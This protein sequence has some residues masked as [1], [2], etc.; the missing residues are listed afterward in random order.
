MGIRGKTLLIIGTT[1]LLLVAGIL[2]AAR[3]IVLGGFVQHEQE[4]TAAQLKRALSMLSDRIA[5]L[6]A[7][8][9]DWAEWDDTYE[10]LG[11]TAG[12]DPSS[13]NLVSSAFQAFGLN[14]VV[15]ALPDG[16]PVYAAGWDTDANVPADTPT[17]VLAGLKPGGQ[18]G[19]VAADNAPV[20]G[21][22]VAHD[23]PLIVA[24]RPVLRSDGTGSPRGVLL[25]GY[26]LDD[27]RIDSLAETGRLDGRI[28]F[29]PL[30]TLRN[31]IGASS[32]GLPD[33]GE[34]V[35]DPSDQNLIGATAVLADVTGRPAVL[36]RSQHERPVFQQGRRTVLFFLLSSLGAAL[37][38]AVIVM[39][40]LDRFVL[41]RVTRM[42]RAVQRITASGDVSAGRL[43][44]TGDDELAALSRAVNTMLTALGEAE[45]RRRQSA[46]ALRERE[47]SFRLIAETAQDMIYRLRLTEPRRFEYVS[48]AARTIFGYAPEEFYADV[49]LGLRAMAPDDHDRGGV[50]IDE[51]SDEPRTFTVKVTRR[52]GQPGWVEHQRVVLR[53]EAGKAIAVQGIARDVTSR[54][55]LLEQVAAA[56]EQLRALSRRQVVMQETLQRQ[57][58]REL[59][60][61][62]G[63]TLTGLKLLVEA[64][65]TEPSAVQGRLD[66]AR[67]L[68]LQ[69]MSYVRN[70]SL[71]LRPTML[72]DL[73]LLPALQFL[74]DRFE[75]QTG[76]AVDFRHRGIDKRFAP[77]VET[78]AYRI[79]QEALT[80]VARHA[81]ATGAQVALQQQQGIMAI[82]VR[83]DGDGFDVERA[84]ASPTNSGLTGMRERASALGGTF[85]VQSEPGRGTRLTVVLPAEEDTATTLTAGE[86]VDIGA[87]RGRSRGGPPGSEGAS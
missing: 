62:I 8:A 22:M 72:D 5:G 3:A 19:S 24:A 11:D 16:E 26:W 78:A 25:F 60:D 45:S 31:D 2:V 47:E 7:I 66:K 52:D 33:V 20:A 81:H 1:S 41:S 79:V 29:S 76:L 42:T 53:D 9:S 4:E 73:G 23:R 38:T 40:L 12:G 59:H 44:A 67:E 49:A 57:I 36:A 71:D 82:E 69:L 13:R 14:V 80:N 32:R 34:V 51:P 37:V 21:I 30:S 35:V 6:E 68:V 27:A 65:L 75:S 74:F 58:A 54:M 56:E 84:E 63:Q 39:L 48:P 43:R 46:A 64:P 83:D 70:L 55:T 77:D 86:N 50:H 18:L 28:A 85:D 10:A 17:D 87:A 61:E 15:L